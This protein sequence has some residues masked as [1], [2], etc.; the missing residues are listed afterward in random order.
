MIALRE[1]RDCH[2]IAWSI[3]DLELFVKRK[4]MPHGRNSI[5][6][7]CQGS[8]QKK[9][10][11][12]EKYQNTKR[13]YAAWNNYGITL[14]EYIKCMNTSKVCQHC[15]TSSTLCYDHDHKTNRFR[16]VL[17][18][19]CNSA[20]GKLGDTLEDIERMYKYLGGDTSK[21]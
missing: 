16:G 15:G 7:V 21:L 17:C 1:C 5:C 3:D 18:R 8:R 9:Y 10:R 13:R 14:E 19:K 4:D 6:K 11:T 2:K 12:G 20:L